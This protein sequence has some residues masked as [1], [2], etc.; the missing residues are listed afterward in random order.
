MSFYLFDN[1]KLQRVYAIEIYIYELPIR[2]TNVLLYWVSNI[3][4]VQ[5]YFCLPENDK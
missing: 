3:Q 2:L 1:W 4:Y 5:G